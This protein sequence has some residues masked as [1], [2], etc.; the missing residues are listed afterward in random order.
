MAASHHDHHAHDGQDS[1]TLV[2]SAHATLHCL[3]GCI[4]G[5]VAGLAIGT[6]LGIGVFWTIVLAVVLAYISGF[7]LAVFP[8]MKRESLTFRQAMSVI[9]L[10]EAISI[11]AMEIAMNGVDYAVGGMTAG[12]VLAPMFWAGIA[13][14]APAG[15]LA[16]WPVNYY[17]LK[18]QLKRCH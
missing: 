16:A 13:A 10:G 2:S 3:T 12:S 9:W 18:R 4:I 6:T 11:G 1:T 14:A 7:T 15:F 8:L 5:E 17:L